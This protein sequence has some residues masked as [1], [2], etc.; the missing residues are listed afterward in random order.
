DADAGARLRELEADGLA[1]DTI[2]FYFAD[3]GSGMPRNKRWPGNSGLQAPLVVYFP[4]KWRD[5]APPDYAAGGKPDRLVNFVDFA[6]TVLSLAGVA[7][8]DMMQGRTFAGPD[9]AD[10]PKY[11]FG[12]RGRIDERV[13]VVR[14]VTDGRFVY[15]R[16]FFPHLP[17]GQH[18]AYQFETPT[19][20]SW[21]RWFDEGRTNAAQSIFWTAPRP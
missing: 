12:E 16:N 17:H 15:L 18:S 21:R 3:H 2:V 13:D 5:L 20:R 14:S 19:T 4:E 11:S 7:P 9:A 6:P 1:D 8:P 10:P